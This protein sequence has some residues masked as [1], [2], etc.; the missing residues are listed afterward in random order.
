MNHRNPA[1]VNLGPRVDPINV[2]S[3]PVEPLRR[4]MPLA[5]LTQCGCRGCSPAPFAPVP[6]HLWLR[7]RVRAAPT[8]GD[9]ALHDRPG[10]TRDLP[11]ARTRRRSAGAPLHRAGATR[12]PPL[13]DSCS[14]FGRALGSLN[15]DILGIGQLSCV[16]APRPATGV[17]S[18]PY[19]GPA[20]GPSSHLMPNAGRARSPRWWSP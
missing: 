5:R 12:V 1:G 15:I 19:G 18:N 4:G 14:R 6:P 10:T 3:L 8:R 11:G 2:S 13:R 16:L 17:M 7:S 20:A 9:R